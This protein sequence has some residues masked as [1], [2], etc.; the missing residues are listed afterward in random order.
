MGLTWSNPIDSIAAAKMT[1]TTLASLP[2]ARKTLT[3]RIST[4]GRGDVPPRS[5]HVPVPPPETGS[6]VTQTISFCTTPS[7]C[8]DVSASV[9]PSAGTSGELPSDSANFF[10]APP[11]AVSPP[12]KPR[13]ASFKS[14]SVA[15]RAPP[16]PPDSSTD[17]TNPD[18]P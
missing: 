1:R 12:P 7:D 10:T 2:D 4:T 6:D 8:S 9:C 15:P 17:D 5:S 14:S 13:T 11:F 16:A 3:G 18:V